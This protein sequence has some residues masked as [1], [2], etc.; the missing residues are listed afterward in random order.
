MSGRSVFAFRRPAPREK[1][2]ATAPVVKR[3]L[4]GKPVVKDVIARLAPEKPV[5]FVLYFL[6]FVALKPAFPIRHGLPGA[7]NEKLL[8]VVVIAKRFTGN[9]SPLL[10]CQL[11]YFLEQGDQASCLVFG[12]G[13]PDENP[14]G[15]IASSLCRSAVVVQTGSGIDFLSI[16]R[17]QA[18]GQQQKR[19]RVN[20]SAMLLKIISDCFMEMGG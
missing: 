4:F 7:Y 8:R 3:F 9:V 1:Q 5:D 19:K 16:V 15:H 18:G 13:S 2:G 14:D 6:P 11:P 20:I 12:H 17:S 10:D